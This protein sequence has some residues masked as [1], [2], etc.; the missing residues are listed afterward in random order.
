MSTYFLIITLS[1]LDRS[2]YSPVKNIIVL[3]KFQVLLYLSLLLLIIRMSLP[4]LLRQTLRN[5]YPPLQY[6]P[7]HVRLSQDHLFL[8]HL[9][10]S[11]EGLLED[12]RLPHIWQIMFAAML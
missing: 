11:K 1:A 5:I 4:L 9:N 7:S 2:D 6:S 12:T 10:C 8:P 3:L